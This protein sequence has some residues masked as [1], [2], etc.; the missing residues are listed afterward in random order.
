MRGSG[1]TKAMVEALPTESST[2]VVHNSAMRSYVEAMIRDVRGTEMWR[3]TKVVVI[4]RQ[5]DVQQLYGLRDHIAFDHAFD[6]SVH[7]AVSAEAHRL[8]TR[9]ASIAG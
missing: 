5:G 6:D 9:A 3:R 7:P 8:A 2:V 1:L 4:A